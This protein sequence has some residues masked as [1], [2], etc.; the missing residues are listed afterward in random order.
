MTSWRLLFLPSYI[1]RLY[2]FCLNSTCCS[3]FQKRSNQ[4]YDETTVLSKTDKKSLLGEAIWLCRCSCDFNFECTA[5]H[6]KENF[7]SR[8]DVCRKF[9]QRKIGK[10]TILNKSKEFSKDKS[11]KTLWECQCDCGQ[12]ILM[13]TL[14][15]RVNKYPSCGCENR[16]AKKDERSLFLAQHEQLISRYRRILDGGKVESN[17]SGKN[18]VSWSKNAWDSRIRFQN[19][20]YLLGRYQEIEDAIAVRVKAENLLYKPYIE[21][22][23]K[24]KAKQLLPVD[25]Y[26][27]TS[28][29]KKFEIWYNTLRHQS[30]SRVNLLINK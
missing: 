7:D 3:G 14:Q 9:G 11:P 12:P 18:G 30:K 26:N 5:S 15:L 16:E 8:C 24:I 29:Y 27:E 17:K 22:Y 10:L 25:N 19:K 20:I 21:W 6:L 1:W 23:E 28:Y 2:S 13:T 4:K